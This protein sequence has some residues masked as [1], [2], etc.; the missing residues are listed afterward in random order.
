MHLVYILE[1]CIHTQHMLNTRRGMR[2]KK[3]TMHQ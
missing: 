1:R 3:A 2:M